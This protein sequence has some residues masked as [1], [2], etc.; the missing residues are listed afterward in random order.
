MH[1]V[2]VMTRKIRRQTPYRCVSKKFNVAAGI[3]VSLQ[4]T[5]A[6]RECASVGS[7]DRRHRRGREA[8]LAT[9]NPS[10]SLCL[11]DL[12]SRHK[13]SELMLY[14]DGRWKTEFASEPKRVHLRLLDNPV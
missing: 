2:K 3:I 11:L 13:R 9:K 14:G 4:R 10:F 1:I 5:N 6:T 8:G 7:R 12:L